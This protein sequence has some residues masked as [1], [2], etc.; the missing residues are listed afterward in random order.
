MDYGNINI[1]ADL[2]SRKLIFNYYYFYIFSFPMIIIICNKNIK[3]INKI[4]E[5]N[6]KFVLGYAYQIISI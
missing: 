6:V 4:K 2:K 5:H 3:Q 1:F